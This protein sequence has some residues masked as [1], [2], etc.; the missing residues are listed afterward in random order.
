MQVKDG[1]VVVTNGSPTVYAVN[2]LTLTG[3]TG[4]FSVGET[5][6]FAP[7]GAAGKVTSYDA[8]GRILSCTVTSAAQPAAGDTVTQSPT[9]A[10][11]AVSGF[12]F[13]PNWHLAGIAPGALFTRSRSGVVYEVGSVAASKV[14]LASNYAGFTESEVAF[15]ISTS[16]TPNASIPYVEDGD[17]D[18]PAITKRAALRIDALLTAVLGVGLTGSFSGN[19][20]KSVRVR[21][22]ENG[23]ELFEAADARATAAYFSHN[24]TVSQQL[25]AFG[26]L[27]AFGGIYSE[28]VRLVGGVGQP[29]FENGWANHGDSVSVRYPAGFWKQADGLVHVRGCIWKSALPVGETIFTLPAGYRPTRLLGVQTSDAAGAPVGFEIGADGAVKKVA[30]STSATFLLLDGISFR[31]EQ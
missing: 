23:L 16:F 24:L 2:R 6:A 30:G 31:G 22:D 21:Q 28:T 27:T 13:Q 14:T 15:S 9:A 17:V 25:T 11:A 29:A 4:G 8:S 1:T 5:L 10:S 26:L 12:A 20:L 3:V 7:S 19:A 18:F